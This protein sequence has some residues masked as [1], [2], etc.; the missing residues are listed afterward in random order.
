M[1]IWTENQ[2]WIF[3]NVFYPYSCQLHDT[4]DKKNTFTMFKI[5]LNENF[6][7]MVTLIAHKIIPLSL[8]YWCYLCF[9]V[10]VSQRG[11]ATRRHQL[12]P[13]HRRAHGEGFGQL[14]RGEPEFRDYLPQCTVLKEPAFVLPISLRAQ[15]PPLCVPGKGTTRRNIVIRKLETVGPPFSPPSVSIW[16]WSCS[17]AT[18][19][20]FFPLFK[21]E[22]NH[23]LF[24]SRFFFWGGGQQSD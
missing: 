1:I 10:A 2:A 3:E 22:Q 24:S 8:N 9:A 15:S 11:Q 4:E 7:N 17:I 6:N 18:L 12:W 5:V 14:E 19:L 23:S 20:Q 16:Y 13:Q 21:T